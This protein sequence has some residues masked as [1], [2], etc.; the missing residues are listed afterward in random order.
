MWHYKGNPMQLVTD[1]CPSFVSAK[2]EAFLATAMTQVRVKKPEIKKKGHLQYTRPLQVVAERA[3]ATCELSDGK[4]WNAIHLSHAHY[5]FHVVPSHSDGVRE[6]DC[7]VPP[8]VLPP[9]ELPAR[10]QQ[11]HMQ[12]CPLA[13]LSDFET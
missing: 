6:Q 9:A 10:S 11:C 2:F 5:P 12:I 1:N 7:Y 8:Q 3:A 4:V 13:W